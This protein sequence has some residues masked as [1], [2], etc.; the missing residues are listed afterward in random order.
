M[1]WSSV[2]L[3]ARLALLGKLGQSKTGL[4]NCQLTGWGVSLQPPGSHP[5]VAL[6]IG[7]VAPPHN[8]PASYGEGARLLM[9]H[10][11]KERE[12]ARL[13]ARC[14]QRGKGAGSCAHVRRSWAVHATRV[15][16]NWGAG[17]EW[18]RYMAGRDLRERACSLK[19]TKVCNPQ[20]CIQHCI[21]PGSWTALI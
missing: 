5:A 2:L 18:A 16:G 13:L 12:G 3:Q 6:S 19:G 9:L 17:G 15:R 1:P 7:L 14:T 4:S 21:H 8:T 10:A 20:V 11:Q